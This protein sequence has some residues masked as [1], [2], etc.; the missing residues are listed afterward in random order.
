MWRQ[1]S[2]RR[3]PKRQE[4]RKHACRYPVDAGVHPQADPKTWDPKI[5]SQAPAA[6]RPATQKP[7]TQTPA[8]RGRQEPGGRSSGSKNPSGGDPRGSDDLNT[9]GPK[10]AGA[11]KW[12]ET[13]Y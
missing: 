3:R 13:H 12:M 4:L 5:A 7:T 10:A 6:Q 8:A 1:E 11:R 2:R 9:C